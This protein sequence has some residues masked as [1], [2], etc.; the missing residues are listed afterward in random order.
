MKY[1]DKFLLSRYKPGTMDFLETRFLRDAAGADNKDWQRLLALEDRRSFAREHVRDNPISGSLS[2]AFLPVAEMLYKG[3]RS[4]VGK[5][6]G[7]RSGFFDPM[8]NIGAGWTGLGQGV[9]DL[10]RDWFSNGNGSQEDPLMDL[11]L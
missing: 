7:G 1:D 11:Y 2:M 8:A 5:D 10:F 3:A 9:S 6:P 4:A